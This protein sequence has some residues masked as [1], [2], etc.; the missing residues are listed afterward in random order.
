MAPDPLMPQGRFRRVL[1]LAGL[2]AQTAG[3]RVI[4]GLRERAGDADALDEFRATAAQRY[5][6]L[7]GR[8]KGVLMKAGQL[9]GML[10]FA[11]VGGDTLLPYQQEL[12]RLQAD[13][14]EMPTSLVLD[15]V[16]ADLGRPLRQVFADFNE[17]PM[18]AASVGQVHEATLADG[19][20]VAVKVQ[21]PGAAEAIRADLLNLQLLETFWRYLLGGIGV[22]M[23]DM[24]QAV[25][26]MA[27]RIR[28]EVDYCREAANVDT[29]A[30]LYRDHPFIRVPEVISEAS[31]DRVL[32]LT[33]MEGMDWVQ[34]HQHADQDLKNSWAEAV[35]RFLFG[36]YRHANLMYGDP[37]PDNCRFRSDGTVAFVDYG[38]VQVVPEHDRWLL[39]AISRAIIEDRAAD[40]FRMLPELG[41][42][43]HDMH[44]RADPAMWDWSRSA[45]SYLIGPQPFTYSRESTISAIGT[46][47]NPDRSVLRH[48]SL[49][50][51]YA[52]G[53]RLAAALVAIPVALDATIHTRAALDDMDGVAEPAT[54]LGEQHVAWVRERGLPFGMDRHNP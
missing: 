37:H 30:T 32:T 51:T 15:I 38:C 29:F 41:F 14:P 16:A 22:P 49:P 19:R 27:A 21:Y 46:F 9:Y 26:E 18:A 36:S 39:V 43:E 28:E 53:A 50:G 35:V 13:A 44:L 24:R 8:S 42:V 17:H 48:L 45:H 31:G 4:A 54:E 40:F 5:G 6:E 34:A 33:Y 20:R 12:Q 25:R 10:D 47:I 7:F 1:P 3:A 11:L 23:L 52:V 2:T